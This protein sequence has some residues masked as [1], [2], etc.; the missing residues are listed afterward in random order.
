MADVPSPDVTTVG[1]NYRRSRGRL[2][3]LLEGADDAAWE[4]PVPACPGWRVRDVLA[5]LVGV[6]EDALAGVISGPPTPVQIR[7]AVVA[8]VRSSRT[9]SR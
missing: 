6:V 4:T 5:H 9:V 3:A 8:R 1:E 2:T 7:L